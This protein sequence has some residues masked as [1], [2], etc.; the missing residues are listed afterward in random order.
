MRKVMALL[1]A[2]VLGVVVAAPAGAADKGDVPAVLNFKMKS[3]DGKDVDLSKYQGKVVLIV[4]V[5]SKCGNTP[6]YKDLEALYEKYGKDGFVVLGFPCNQF[7]K[8]EPG[9]NE[10]IAEFCSKNYGV[11]FDLFDKI[12]V[13]GPNAAPLYK[14]LTSADTN[15]KHAGKIEWNFQKYLISKKGEVV[16]KFNHRT[17]PSAPEV[18][19]A[20]ETELKK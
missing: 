20:I 17:K 5:A 13:N 16:G 14:F 19:Q 7:G 8:Q 6:Q 11:T 9:T 2:L 10:Q 4:N 1:M 12:D 15:P 3:L 18:V